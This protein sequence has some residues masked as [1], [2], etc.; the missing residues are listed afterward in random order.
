FLPSPGATNS[1][2]FT[3][4]VDFVKF[5]LIVDAGTNVGANPSTSPYNDTLNIRSTASSE[6][7]IFAEK[8]KGTILTPQIQSLEY[9]KSYENLEFKKNFELT[10][11]VVVEDY[12]SI[13][14]VGSSGVNHMNYAL[15]QDNNVSLISAKVKS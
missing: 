4:P 5:V 7:K 15:T 3:T 11:N 2:T 9:A 10:P 6:P 8:I 14:M 13:G 12:K 1:F